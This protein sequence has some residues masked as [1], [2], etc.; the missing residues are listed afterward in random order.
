[1]PMSVVQ[2]VTIEVQGVKNVSEIE[3]KSKTKMENGSRFFGI[4][5][6]VLLT[7]FLLGS[8]RKKKFRFKAS[9]SAVERASN[10][11]GKRV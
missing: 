11:T 3:K 2:L 10:Q 5:A 6:G 9:A 4:A 7:G 1:M 8:G